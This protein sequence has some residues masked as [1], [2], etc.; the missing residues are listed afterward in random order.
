MSR[1]NIE[2]GN[3]IMSVRM[4]VRMCVCSLSKFDKVNVLLCDSRAD[5]V[6]V[7]MEGKWFRFGMCL[8]RSTTFS[9]YDPDCGKR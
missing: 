1:G 8:L 5:C 2:F 7:T 3:G 4:Y 9:S 6:S